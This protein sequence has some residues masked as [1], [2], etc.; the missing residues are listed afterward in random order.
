MLRKGYGWVEGDNA[1]M[2]VGEDIARDALA[3]VS[4][5][6]GLRFVGAEGIEVVYNGAVWRRYV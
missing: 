2:G 5:T 4:V 1:G 6:G 3:K